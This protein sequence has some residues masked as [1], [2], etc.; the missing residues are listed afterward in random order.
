[1]GPAAQYVSLVIQQGIER[2][3]SDIHIDPT[4]DARGRVRLRVDGVLH[5]I[6]PPPEGTYG[7][8]ADRIKGMAGMDIAETGLPQDG[9][10]MLDVSGKPIDL[11]VSTLPTFHGERVVMRILAREAP[12][13]DLN[14]I[15]LVDDDLAKVREL[16]HC[17]HGIILAAGPTGSGKTTLFYA[18]LNEIDREH[19]CVL[20]VEDPVE[21]LLEGVAQT[22]IRPQVGLTFARAVRQLLRQDPDVILIGEI[23]DAEVANLAVQCALT[24]HVVLTTLHAATAPGGIKRL[25]DMGLEPFLVNASVAGVI[26]QRLVRMLCPECKQQVEV[27]LHSLPPQAIELMKEADGAAFCGPRGCNACN[28][29]GYRGR[30]AIHEILIPDDRVKDVVASDGHLKEI[31]EAALAAGMKTMLACG[32]EKAARGITSLQ[33]VLRVIPHGP[34][35]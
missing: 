19:V 29:T 13:L 5:D 23:R 24:G 27:P 18:M 14:E 10:I 1:M 28:G 3:A 15:G 26:S 20:T 17:L 4:D 22:Q 11:R 6:E 9:R 8:V 7:D 34:N 30:T 16:C 32:V 21:Y 33:E 25:V 31:R 12:R 35:D 2:R